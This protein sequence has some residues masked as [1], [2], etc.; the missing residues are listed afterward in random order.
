M[1]FNESLRR[2]VCAVAALVPA[3]AAAQAIEPAEAPEATAQATPAT[4]PAAPEVVQFFGEVRKAYNQLSEVEMTGQIQR[5]IDVAGQQEKD[6]TEFTSSFKAPNYFRHAIGDEMV[7]GSTG[8]KTY[9][10]SPKENAFLQFDL[11]KDQPLSKA[12]PPMVASAV[13]QQ[14]PSLWQVVEEDAMAKSEEI[15]SS[16]EPVEDVMIGDVAFRAFRVKA[17]V[18]GPVQTIVFDP[19]TFMIRRIV[20]DLK[21]VLIAQGAPDV[22]SAEITVEYTNVNTKAQLAADKFAWTAPEGAR[23]VVAEAEAEMAQQP[24]MQLRGQAAPAFEGKTLTGEKLALADLKGKVVVLDFWATWC[25][26]CIEG[27]PALQEIAANAGDDVKVVTINIGEDEAAVNEFLRTNKLTL[28]I[29]MDPEMKI[30]D[31]YK[32]EPIP[33]QVVIDKEGKVQDVFIGT[34]PTS[35]QKLKEAVEKAKAATPAGEQG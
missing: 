13:Q 20:T 22:K 9:A 11:E 34:G 1:N 5:D 29:V 30:A 26:P 4:Q 12:L 35:K 24:S 7:V 31:Q 16:M 23:D 28:P 32:V 27:M 10:F 2:C 25:A 21:P 6:S 17:P 14:N 15:A 18:D 8:E 3:V 19:N 33:H